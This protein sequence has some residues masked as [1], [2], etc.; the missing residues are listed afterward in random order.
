MP[1]ADGDDL[2]NV[3][4][5]AVDDAVV[6]EKDLTDVGASEFPDDTAGKWKFLKM[7][8][9]LEHVIFPFP[10][11]GPIAAFLRERRRGAGVYVR[12]ERGFHFLVDIHLKME[13]QS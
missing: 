1:V 9:R 8:N 3:V 10:C 5:H 2:G 7:G 11:R 13:L 4:L 12:V 6:A